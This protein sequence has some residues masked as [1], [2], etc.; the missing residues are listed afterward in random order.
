MKKFKTK[1]K[2]KRKNVIFIVIAFIFIMLFI[3]I[4]MKN[5]SSNHTKFINFLLEQNDFI[6]KAIVLF[7]VILL[8]T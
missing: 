5:L 6:E 8:V 4:S 2:T 1:R 7:F 3:F